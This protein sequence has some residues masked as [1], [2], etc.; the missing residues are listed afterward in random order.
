MAKEI[1]ETASRANDHKG[2]SG[3]KDNRGGNVSDEKVESVPQGGKRH[4]P[5][6]WKKTE[7]PSGD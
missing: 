1:D 5:G 2:S 3:G 7:D 6:H 4:E